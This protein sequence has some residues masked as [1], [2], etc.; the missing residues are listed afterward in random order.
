MDDQTAEGN[1]APTATLRWVTDALDL[2]RLGLRVFP[3]R[4]GTKKPLFKSYRK[5]ATLDPVVIRAWGDAHGDCNLGVMIEPGL[6]VLDVDP[7]NGG[8]ESLRSLLAAHR[9]FRTVEALTGS[10]GSHYLF[11]VGKGDRIRSKTNWRPGLDI[12]SEGKYFV[13]E[14]ST[15]P[16]TG[17]EYVWLRH[18]GQGI[19]NLPPW[20]LDLLPKRSR[21]SR[22]G[23]SRRPTSGKKA[24]DFD[25][26]LEFV[27]NS[28]PIDA[29]GQRHDRMRDAVCSLVC[30]G[31]DDDLI[32]PVMMIWWEHFHS[33]GRV[34]TGRAGMSRELLACLRCTRDNP[35]LEAIEGAVWHRVRCASI[36]LDRSQ[37]RQM[38]S[39]ILV[40]PLGC[41]S[42]SSAGRG[43]VPRPQTCKNLTQI[44]DILCESE[45]EAAFV[46]SLIVHV[47]H[48][49]LD[50]GEIEVRMTDD[51]LRQI[52]AERRPTDWR[53]WCDKQMDRLKAKYF[54]R[55]GRGGRPARPATRFE[56]LRVIETGT[57]TRGSRPAR[58]SIYRTT[59]IEA[60]LAPEAVQATAG[61]R[62][63]AARLDLPSTG[64]K[65]AA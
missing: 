56:L 42:L 58:P 62:H 9:S 2:A 34:R 54:W 11:R 50:L 37:R 25:R 29:Y 24:G 31:D 18:P 17:K 26:L 32:V 13:V 47:T 21:R 7:R 40:D 63:L 49:R 10:G 3:L 27:V 55:P 43:K 60:L 38:K 41:K 23:S 53:P 46:E 12:L 20:L 28:F 33:L 5:R 39:P 35:D 51:F 1:A 19:G 45:D 36:C 65:E 61:S 6:V 44:G 30:R 48:R 15:H 4:A 8:A 22:T 59:G 57:P 14:P 16:D 64:N 52:A